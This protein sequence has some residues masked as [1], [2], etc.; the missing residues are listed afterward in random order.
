MFLNY[1]RNSYLLYKLKNIKQPMISQ[2]QPWGWT[3]IHVLSKI[4]DMDVSEATLVPFCWGWLGH[5]AGGIYWKISIHFTQQ[6]CSTVLQMQSTGNWV[7]SIP[8][9]P[10]VQGHWWSSFYLESNPMSLSWI[11][12]L[13]NNSELIGFSVTSSSSTKQR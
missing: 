10:P 8:L 6:D 3:N 12:H 1:K 4:T 11:S 5:R 7:H 2:S 9:W 13:P